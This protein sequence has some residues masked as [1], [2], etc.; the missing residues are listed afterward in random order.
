MHSSNLQR[1]LVAAKRIGDSK[2]SIVKFSRLSLSPDRNDYRSLCTTR[3]SASDK[4]VAVVLSG[5]GV[6]DG[7]EIHEAAA[8]LAA[9]TRHGATPVMYSPDKPQHHVVAHNTGQGFKNIQQM[10]HISI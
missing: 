8:C 1:M 4:K 6:Y 9:L 3:P 5:C 7:T 2:I 10:E